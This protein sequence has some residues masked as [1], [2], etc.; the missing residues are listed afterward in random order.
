MIHTI[1]EPIPYEQA[2]YAELEFCVKVGFEEA[3]PMVT[4]YMKL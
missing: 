4:Y 2:Y 1:P 3:I